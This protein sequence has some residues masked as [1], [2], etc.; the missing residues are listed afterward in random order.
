LPGHR[1]HWPHIPVCGG[2]LP[3]LTTFYKSTQQSCVQPRVQGR[4][5]R[6][7]TSL[8]PA[9]RCVVG[10]MEPALCQLGAPHLTFPVWLISTRLGTCRKCFPL[11]LPP[12]GQRRMLPVSPL[13]YPMSLTKLSRAGPSPQSTP[14]YLAPFLL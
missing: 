1:Y 4:I 7:S 6:Q 14:N 9:C 11:F 3:E 12:L 2:T 13:N 10:C 5:S 8:S